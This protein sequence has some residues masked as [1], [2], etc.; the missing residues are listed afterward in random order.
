VGNAGNAGS[1]GSETA[2]DVDALAS[3][4]GAAI[5]I[6]ATNPAAATIRVLIQPIRLLVCTGFSCEGPRRATAP[7]RYLATTAL[8]WTVNT[9]TPQAAVL[10]RI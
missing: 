4:T 3:A 8:P 5:A 9:L 7:G 2:G 6:A 1:G 10:A